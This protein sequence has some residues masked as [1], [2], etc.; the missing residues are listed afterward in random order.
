MAIGKERNRERVKIE[1]NSLVGD[2]AVTISLNEY[3]DGEG[4]ERT[5]VSKEQ[6][7]VRVVA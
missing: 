3:I 2:M 1:K 6:E 4:V 7:G 5:N